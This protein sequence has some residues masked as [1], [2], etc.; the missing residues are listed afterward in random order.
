M[1]ESWKMKKLLFEVNGVISSEYNR[2][3]EKFGPC[4]NSDH[5]SY[6]VLKE[7]IEEAKDEIANMEKHF[8]DFWSYV[9][10]NGADAGKLEQLGALEATARLAAAEMIQVAA[11]AR[12]A[13]I[14]IEKRTLEK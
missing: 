3:A 13:Q 4:N 5:E 10:N 11:M 2:A 8:N 6:A 9:K 14:T 7:E 1:Q 12:K